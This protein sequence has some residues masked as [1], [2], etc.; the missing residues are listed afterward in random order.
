M[1]NSY[2]SILNY[3][4]VESY[5]TMLSSVQLHL[6]LVVSFIVIRG[7]HAI[8]GDRPVVVSGLSKGGSGG[9]PFDDYIPSIA[10]VHAIN[11]SYDSQVESI[12]VTYRLINGSLYQAPKHGGYRHPPMTITLAPGEYISEIKG[13][14]NGVLVDQMSIVT[15]QPKKFLKKT[16][17]PFGKTGEQ[18]FSMEGY[19]VGFFGRS[20]SLLDNIGLH[21][22]SPVKKSEQFGL[23]D[24]S[25]FDENPDTFFP[26][27]VLKIK[28]IHISHGHY[29]NDIN[30]VYAIQ[31]EYQLLNGSVQP[32]A[33]HGGGSGNWTT[34]EIADTEWLLGIEGQAGPNVGQLTFIVGGED[35]SIKQYGPYG[36]A[37]VTKYAVQPIFSAYGKGILG[38]AGS[39]ND[40]LVALIVYYY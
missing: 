30:T 2:Q 34:I 10:G 11:I 36:E 9:D 1:H 4:T 39:A 40:Y 6:V 14:T 22:L 20:G 37:Y 5:S 25:N 8:P 19:V 17:G 3:E 32:G 18:D 21:I 28:K 35:G 33:V 31:A 29:V 15:F 12:Q 38:F 23:V 24:W 27:P 7:G 16:Y 26:S 13:K